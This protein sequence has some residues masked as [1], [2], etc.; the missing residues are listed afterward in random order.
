MNHKWLSIIRNVAACI[1]FVIGIGQFFGPY[2][3]DR[4]QGAALLGLS[5]VIARGN[6][7]GRANENGGSKSMAVLVVMLLAL[8]A[9]AEIEA[10]ASNTAQI[11]D[12][13]G[14]VSSIQSAVADIQ[15]SLDRR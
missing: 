8:A 6:P 2:A 1:T 15:D 9:L 7:W 5:Y 10:I 4:Q 14:D 13:Q 12:I 3:R 11:G